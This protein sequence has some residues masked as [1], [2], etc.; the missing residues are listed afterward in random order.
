MNTLFA[1]AMLLGMFVIGISLWALG[2]WLHRRGHNH[3]LN[4]ILAKL[5]KSQRI[6]G[7][8]LD[9]IGA[10]FIG[11]ARAISQ[12]PFLKKPR[13]RKIWD[14]LEELKRLRRKDRTSPP[15]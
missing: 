5:P 7:R 3:R 6:A 9:Q 14:D 15:N 8:L 10:G 1:V 12:V 2:Q 11:F 4:M 13:S